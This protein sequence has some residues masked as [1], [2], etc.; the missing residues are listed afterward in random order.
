MSRNGRNPKSPA[1]QFYPGDFLA[2]PKVQ[3]MTA[4]EVGVYVILLCQGWIDGSI[5]ND[6]VQLARRA[7]LTPA[8]FAR[9]W[10]TVGL[11]WTESE[12]GRLVNPRQERERAFQAANRAKMAELSK[13][14][15]EARQNDTPGDRTVAENV[16]RGDLPIPDTQYPKPDKEVVDA[17]RRPVSKPVP[18]PNYRE[19]IDAWCEV[20]LQVTGQPYGFNGGV[21]GKHVKAILAKAKGDVGLIRER[22]TILL[23]AAPEWIDAGGKDL[24][25]LNSQWNKLVSQGSGHA[26]GS[27]LAA[28]NIGNGSPQPKIIPESSGLFPVKKVAQ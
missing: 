27:L 24:G 17:P 21:D 2:D 22:S 25:T 19:A 14:G 5:P 28:L 13:K 9:A 8:R 18:V 3:A 20:F 15:V 6:H 4:E 16:P 12:S 1:F 10:V 11:C 7:R 23:R 26:T